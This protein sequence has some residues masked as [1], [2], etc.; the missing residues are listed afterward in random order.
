[1]RKELTVNKSLMRT[2]KYYLRLVTVLLICAFFSTG[3]LRVFANDNITCSI[4][5]DNSSLNEETVL[6]FNEIEAYMLTNAN[7]KRIFNM[8]AALSN[9]ASERAIAIGHI[10][11]RWQEDYWIPV[12]LATI[13]PFA[14]WHNFSRYGNYCGKGNYGWDKDPID[15]LDA[16]CRRHDQCYDNDPLGYNHLPC[17]GAFCRELKAII[18]NSSGQKY[19]YASAA[20]LLFA[21]KQVHGM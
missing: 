16:A 8:D 5:A 7:G 6:L 2:K 4:G 9:G 11:N 20:F 3:P 17:D 10:I 13:V 15:N 21:C 1:M 12:N 18:N 14:Q 19:M